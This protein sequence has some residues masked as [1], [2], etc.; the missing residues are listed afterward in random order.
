M[1]TLGLGLLL[2]AVCWFAAYAAHASDINVPQ[3]VDAG[4]GFTVSA[5]GS[6]KAVMVL[7]GPLGAVKRDVQLGGDLRILP[8]EIQTSGHYTLVLRSGGASSQASFWVEPA[9]TARLSFLA[10]P[11]RLPVAMPNAISGVVYPTDKFYNLVLRPEPVTFKLSVADAAPVTSTVTAKNGV[12]WVS[13]D[14][15]RKTGAAQFVATIGDVSERRVVQEVASD[16]C[17]LRIRAQRSKDGVEVETD[18]I[19]DCSGNPVPDGTI[20]TFTAVSPR[21]KSSV[22]ARIKK[23]VAKAEFPQLG[24]ATISVA[25]GV[26]MGNEVHVGGGGE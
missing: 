3:R 23:G 26:V 8:E 24:N 22:D 4:A 5:P 2:V 7:I 6:G 15:T 10:R 20:V 13:F 17:N 1:K 25:S 21:G 18:P 11:S 19:R 12:A 16:P 9:K 14:S